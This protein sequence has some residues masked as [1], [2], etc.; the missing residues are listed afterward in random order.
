M[1]CNH[2][3][4]LN[5]QTLDLVWVC[6]LRTIYV[7]S[8]SRLR[9]ISSAIEGDATVATTV[10]MYGTCTITRNNTLGTL[11]HAIISRV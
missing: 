7:R 2:F 1:S 10:C 4:C 8:S 9:W 11:R 6:T 3:T 5:A